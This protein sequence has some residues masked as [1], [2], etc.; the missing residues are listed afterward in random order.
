MMN[1]WSACGLCKAVSLVMG[2]HAIR[3]LL[4]L[5]EGSFGDC[6]K[7]QRCCPLYMALAKHGLE[8]CQNYHV[9]GSQ[10]RLH[11]VFAVGSPPQHVQHS[12]SLSTRKV[13]PARRGARSPEQA[14]TRMQPSAARPSAQSGTNH[15]SCKHGVG[16]RTHP[17]TYTHGCMHAHTHTQTHIQTHCHPSASTCHGT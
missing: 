2:L 7:A 15:C 9:Y 17:P 8:T 6:Q 14:H 1:M 13:P 10:V 4:I 16:T 3:L 11:L 5:R 12:C